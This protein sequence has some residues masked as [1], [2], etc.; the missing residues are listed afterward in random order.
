M[1]ELFADAFAVSSLEDLIS[2]GLKVAESK[3]WLSRPGML[4]A[5]YVN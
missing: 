1:C 4:E 2:A 5:I 3:G